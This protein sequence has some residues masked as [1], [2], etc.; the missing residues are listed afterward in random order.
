MAEFFE[1]I[2]SGDYCQ[3]IGKY[4][5]QLTNKINYGNSRD[6]SPDIGSTIWKLKALSGSYGAALTNHIGG[7]LLITQPCVSDF[8]SSMYAY[9]ALKKVLAIC[10]IIC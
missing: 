6:G 2:T 8:S 1:S 4:Q 7:G 5:W 9:T 3:S 10:S